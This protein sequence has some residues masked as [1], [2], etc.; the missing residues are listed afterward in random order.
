MSE[1]TTRRPQ[2]GSWR[3]PKRRW[4]QTLLL[5]ILLTLAGI[6][7]TAVAS[8]RYQIRPVLSGS[9]RPGLPVGGVVVTE[10]VPLSDINVRDVIVFTNPNDPSKRVVHRVISLRRT[11]STVIAKTQGDA[12]N[13]PDPWTLSLHGSTAYRAVYTVPLIGYPAVWLQNVGGRGL[14]LLATGVALVIAVLAIWRKE[15]RKGGGLHRQSPASGSEIAE[16][17]T[18]PE[19]DCVVADSISSNRRITPA[20]PVLDIVQHDGIELASLNYEAIHP[21]R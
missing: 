6:G 21:R 13:A 4:V 12:N 14:L 5:A 7:V 3:A 20:A 15:R 19:Q 1:Q 2:R 11:G 16:T 17:K 8:G 10:R 18:E 9:M